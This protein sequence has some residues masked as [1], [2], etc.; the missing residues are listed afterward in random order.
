ME[1]LGGTRIAVNSNTPANLKAFALSANSSITLNVN[2]NSRIA[3]FSIANNQAAM[4]IFLLSS[5]S[6]GA[7]HRTKIGTESNINIT[8]ASIGSITITN[9]G[10]SGGGNLYAV[11]FIGDISQAT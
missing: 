9:S 8:N 7:V 4:A 10:T 5:T 2:N 6:A 11:C 1:C 3:I